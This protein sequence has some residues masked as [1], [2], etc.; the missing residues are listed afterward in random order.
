MAYDVT[1]GERISWDDAATDHIRTRSARYPA[2]ADIDPAWTVEVVHDPDR[3][4]DEPDPRSA[5]INSVRIVGYSRRHGWS[6]PSLRCATRTAGCTVRPR[7]S[8]RAPRC[9]STW[10]TDAMTDTTDQDL[11]AYREEAEA[12]RDEPLSARAARPGRQRAKVLSVRLSADEFD[13]LTRYA[14]ALDLPASALARG[15]ILDQLRRQLVA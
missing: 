5:H 10:R 9:A 13:D 4:V 6:S 14:A 3:L 2:A 12:A 15:W 7:G 8:P 11:R 1:R